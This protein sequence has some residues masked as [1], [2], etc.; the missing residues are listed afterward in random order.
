L[1]TGM[2]F[3]FLMDGCNFDVN[4]GCLNY[5]ETKVTII[6]HR[7]KKGSWDFDHP[8]KFDG[9]AI[10]IDGRNRTCKILATSNDHRDNVESILEGKYKLGTNL[11][12]YKRK[13]SSSKYCHEYNELHL[14]WI[15]GVSMVLAA[16]LLLLLDTIFRNPPSARSPT[17][18]PQ[19]SNNI[20]PLVAHVV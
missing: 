10:A 13:N 16:I 18:H 4:G 7:I 15:I 11:T 14:N 8:Y 20:V 17:V 1:L 6:D 9:L 3:N 12:L 19:T 5:Y 2:S